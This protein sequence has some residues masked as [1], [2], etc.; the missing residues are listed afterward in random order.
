MPELGPESGLCTVVGGWLFWVRF[1]SVFPSPFSLV[2]EPQA[3]VSACAA[4]CVPPHGVPV[5]AAVLVISSS[6]LIRFRWLCGRNV[7]MQDL[8]ADLCV[9]GYIE[10]LMVGA[11]VWYAC[12]P[13]LCF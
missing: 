4:A 9:E 3:F 2:E 11:V 8:T 13:T 7:R 1:P 12:I 6:S 10:M 5:P